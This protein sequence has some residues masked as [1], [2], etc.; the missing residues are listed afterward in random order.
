MAD[1]PVAR[2]PHLALIVPVLNEAGL[3]PG[4]LEHI[5]SLHGWQECIIADGG[6]DDNSVA[7]AREHAVNCH[8]LQVPGGRHRQLNAALAHTRCQGVLLLAADVRLHRHAC[9]QVRQSVAAGRHGCLR[10]RSA[11][12]SRL[13]RAQDAASRLRARLLGGA[14]MDQVP[15]FPSTALRRIGGFR[16]LGPYDSADAG[17][18]LGARHFAALPIPALSSCRAYRHGFWRQTLHNQHHRCRYMATQVQWEE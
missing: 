18:R 17:Y 3:L 10:Q 5:R 13:M 12:A 2:V 16:A 1:L 15:F 4:L 7:I 9:L 14:Y 11:L 8:V 6:S